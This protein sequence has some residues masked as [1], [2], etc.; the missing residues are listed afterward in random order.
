[1]AIDPAI[2]RAMADAGA[3]VEVIIAAVEAAAR[4][5]EER[6]ERKRVN[7]AE[8]QQ[9]HRDK[10]ASRKNNARNALPGVTPPIDRTHTPQADISPDGENQRAAR[11]GKKTFFVK[12]DWADP[13]Q[14]ADFLTNRKRK[15]L[16]DSAS[17]YAGFLSD[18]AAIADAEWPPGRLLAH[19]AAKGWGSINDPRGNP[20]ERNPRPARVSP[21]PGNRGTRPNPLVDILA[22]I[23]AEER[24]EG[25]AQGDFGA[26]PPVRAIG[27]G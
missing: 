25:S 17:A 26:W 19:A 27:T 3:S 6:R 22:N 8:R 9:R 18:I 23:A 5:E 21:P 11:S 2:L 12:P 14:W 20:N 4:K 10:R 24:S 15:R 13:Q 16:P 7:N 1:M